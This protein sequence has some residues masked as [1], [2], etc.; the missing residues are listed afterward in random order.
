[1]VPSKVLFKLRSSTRWGEGVR[2]EVKIVPE[3]RARDSPAL[4]GVGRG[5]TLTLEHANGKLLLERLSNN[6]RYS[7]GGTCG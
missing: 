4:L 6:E 1:M 5:I 2:S 7:A 3:S